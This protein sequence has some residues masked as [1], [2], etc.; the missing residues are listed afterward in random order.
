MDLK[1]NSHS[2]DNFLFLDQIVQS[3]KYPI[4]F[5]SKNYLRMHEVL[6]KIESITDYF[7]GLYGMSSI[8][9]AK[10]CNKLLKGLNQPYLFM[11]E[12]E[13]LY[14]KILNRAG[15]H[16]Q[17]RFDI[18][19]AVTNVSN[20]LVS[21]MLHFYIFLIIKYFEFYFN[22]LQDSYRCIQTCQLVSDLDMVGLLSNFHMMHF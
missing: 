17:C 19:N 2:S 13:L 12:I 11:H 6:I 7:P 16:H 10:Q 4:Y 18:Q 1:E 8:N 9:L 20:V 22:H 3:L 14:R 21:F 5:I 15:L